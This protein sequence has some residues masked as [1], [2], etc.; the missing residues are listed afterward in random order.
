M[1]Q[2]IPQKGSIIKMPSGCGVILDIY[3]NET[4]E[5]ILKILY[6]KNIVK[7]QDP[8]LLPMQLANELG[9]VLADEAAFYADLEVNRQ[10]YQRQFDARLR[11]LQN[12]LAK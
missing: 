6:A 1:T 11:T 10:W 7:L 3:R 4:G 12:A 8:E 9:F 5:A 2:V